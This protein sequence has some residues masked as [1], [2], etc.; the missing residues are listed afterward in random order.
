M[1]AADGLSNDL[2]RIDSA[3][4]GVLNLGNLGGDIDGGLLGL[5]G[6]RFD[7][8][9]DHGESAS[10]FPGP[11]RFNGR[12][13]RQQIGLRGNIGND[14]NNVADAIRRHPQAFNPLHNL[15]GLN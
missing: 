5:G 11:C 3:D 4:V 1:D 9:R 12:I 2:N 15:F 6:E 8:P 13:Q 14:L 10:G 7:F